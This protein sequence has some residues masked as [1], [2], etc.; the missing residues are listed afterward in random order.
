MRLCVPLMSRAIPQ[1]AP[2]ARTMQG[3]ACGYLPALYT[4]YYSARRTCAH[5]VLFCK[6]AHVATPAGGFYNSD[7]VLYVSTYSY[8][9]ASCTR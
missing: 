9:I 5:V 3:G 6:R 1:S 2:L 7:N 4:W 8:R